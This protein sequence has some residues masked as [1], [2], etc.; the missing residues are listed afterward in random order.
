MSRD[1]AQWAVDVV[2]FRSRR[3]SYIVMMDLSKVWRLALRWDSH[4]K[5]RPPWVTWT[6]PDISRLISPMRSLLWGILAPFM[7]I[8]NVT[9]KEMTG[10][11]F[12]ADLSP[13]ERGLNLAYRPATDHL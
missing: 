2:Y 7:P 8:D 10:Q 11:E 6:S 9:W 4:Q 13:A 3:P 5:M 1:E 12:V